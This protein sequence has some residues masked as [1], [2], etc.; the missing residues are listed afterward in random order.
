M[1]PAMVETTTLP[2]PG[3]TALHSQVRQLLHSRIS[4]GELPVG[5]R[6][7]S[8][9]VL[10]TELGISRVTLRRALREL[11][12]DGVLTAA[13]GRGWFVATE[14]VGEPANVLM[15]F[16]AMAALRGLRPSATVLLQRERPSSLEEAETFL[17][18]PGAPLFELHRVRR[19][20]GLAIAI[21]EVR[22]P[23]AIVGELRGI[24]FTTGSLH[25]ELARAGVTPESS[26]CTV[27]ATLA[28]DDQA[29]LL[30]TPPGSAVLLVRQT[31]YDQHGRVL[32]LNVSH[33]RGDR[34][35]F[36]T[37]L[38]ATDAGTA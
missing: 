29:V 20:D 16:S 21:E 15:S 10:C 34:Y 37:T 23:T 38:R 3:P 8:E 19:L 7:P 1:V 31:T 22:L 26:T 9:R 27:E 11:A 30:D 24:D 36:N 35:R 14:R 33:F 32:E 6:L 12:D 2:V 13:Q 25:A 4:S 17:V 28:T 18:A 5:S